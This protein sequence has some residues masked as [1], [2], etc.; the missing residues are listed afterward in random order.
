MSDIPRKQQR[1]YRGGQRQYIR[2]YEGVLIDV[3]SLWDSPMCSNRK[4]KHSINP[5]DVLYELE[6]KEKHVEYFPEDSYVV[7]TELCCEECKREFE[8][9][10]LE[11]EVLEII[12]VI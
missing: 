11:F 12:E 1:L 2:G 4:R 8:E 9:A 7:E 3:T 6:F 10:G 5:G